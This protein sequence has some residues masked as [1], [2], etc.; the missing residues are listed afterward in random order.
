MR[1]LN[2]C[3]VVI[4]AQRPSFSYKLT[5][6]R[7]IQGPLETHQRPRSA[8]ASPKPSLSSESHLLANVDDQYFDRRRGGRGARSSLPL[9]RRSL[10]A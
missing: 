2:V 6:T 8:A 4:R 10:A 3:P 5:L 1:Q 9:R 7:A